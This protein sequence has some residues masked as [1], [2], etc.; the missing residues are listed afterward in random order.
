M[1]FVSGSNCQNSMPLAEATGIYLL[2]A[3]MSISEHLQIIT[4]VKVWKARSVQAIWAFTNNWCSY[5]VQR[6]VIMTHYAPHR[7]L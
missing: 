5:K 6:R 2:L 7:V 1:K 3:V 4:I